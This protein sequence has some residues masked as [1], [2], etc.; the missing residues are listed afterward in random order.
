MYNTNNPNLLG[1]IDNVVIPQHLKNKIRRTY[2]WDCPYQDYTSKRHFNTQRHIYL[3]HGIGSGEPVDHM[4]GE[5]RDEKRRAANE[6]RNQSMSV[7][8]YPRTRPLPPPIKNPANYCDTRISAPAQIGMPY[9]EAQERRLE[10]LGYTVPAQPALNY[11]VHR[12]GTPGLTNPPRY[13]RM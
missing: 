6:S 3:T 1:R 8:V 4:T 9:L 13:R 11:G 10:E 5:T 2:G 12:D 7:S